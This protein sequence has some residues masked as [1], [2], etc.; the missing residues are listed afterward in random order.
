V[1]FHDAVVT[2]VHWF[3]GASQSKN[4]FP[5]LG[6]SS[7]VPQRGFGEAYSHRSVRLSGTL[8]SQ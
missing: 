6:I 7:N 2:C 4:N 8:S 5:S 1:T 3:N